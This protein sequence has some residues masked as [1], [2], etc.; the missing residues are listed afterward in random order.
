MELAGLAIKKTNVAGYP[1]TVTKYH[2]NNVSF[3]IEGF[4]GTIKEFIASYGDEILSL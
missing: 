2:G 3:K 4:Q 1:I